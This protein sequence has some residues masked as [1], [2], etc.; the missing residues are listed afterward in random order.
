MSRILSSRQADE[1]HKSIVA[2]LSANNL[3]NAVAALRTELGLEE[4]TFDAVT[5]KKYETLLEKKWTSVIRLQKKIMDLE[6]RVAT[7]QSELDSATPSSL[8]NRS[9]DPTSWLPT[10]PARYTL[11]SHQF[12]IS[13]IAFHPLYSTIASG[14]QGST[15]KIWD[16]ELGELERTIK[17]HTKAITGIDFGGP[18][19]HTLLAS[20]SSDLTIKLWDPA[21]AYK[22]IR[23]LSGHDHTVSAV[24]FMPSG[25]LLVSASRDTT[26]R[27]WDVTTGY[28]VK[29][30]RGHLEWVRDVC[31]SP[32]GS[33]ILSTGDDRTV[34][35]WNVSGSVAENKLT[36]FGHENFIEC[37]VF[38]PPSSYQYLATLAGLQKPPPLTSTSEFMATGSRD[39]TIKLWDTRGRCF[40]TLIGHDN[41]VRALVFHPGGKYLISVA[42]DK[43]LRCW[44]LSQDGKCVKEL[45]GLH[46]HFISCLGWAPS[47]VKDKDKLPAN[48]EA[49]GSTPEVKIRCVIATGSVDMALKIF[50]R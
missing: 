20:C 44:D 13:C 50:A 42:D 17:G 39:K 49:G 26:L 10:K 23:T 12:E 15:I 37:C 27:M 8:S 14:D 28:C 30:I 38:A 3:P 34:R 11:E 1:L 43:A 5:V 29:T 48:G 36:L 33:S 19:G 6:S 21:D 35:L 7:L 47:I 24:R 16:W 31:P 32:D 9:Q 40:K 41:W 4:E 45:S 18:K 2:Y 22:N 46:D 25:N